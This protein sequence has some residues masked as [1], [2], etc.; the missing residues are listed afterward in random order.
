MNPKL[1]GVDIAVALGESGGVGCSS[2]LIDHSVSGSLCSCLSSIVTCR[3]DSCCFPV[4]G[5][6]CDSAQLGGPCLLT[7]GLSSM[8]GCL[9]S[10]VI[11]IGKICGRRDDDA[12]GGATG[13]EGSKSG[14]YSRCFPISGLG[15]NLSHSGGV[16]L[17]VNGSCIG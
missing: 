15:W 9:G 10:G 14:E 2:G 12:T 7:N 8:S 6:G 13:S 16:L 4:R 1:E 3:S 17:L 11:Q 5:K